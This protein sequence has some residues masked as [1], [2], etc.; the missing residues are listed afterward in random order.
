MPGR[1]PLHRFVRVLCKLAL[2]SAI[3]TLSA[4][5][6]FYR[7]NVVQIAFPLLLVCIWVYGRFLWNVENPPVTPDHWKGRRLL[8]GLLRPALAWSRR[9][10]P[11]TAQ[12]L[13]DS[14]LLLYEQCRFREAAEKLDKAADLFAQLDDRPNQS[15]ALMDL[16]NCL[17]DAGRHE[18]AIRAHTQALK[19]WEQLAEHQRTNNTWRLLTNL[20]AALSDKG[21]LEAAEAQCRRALDHCRRHHADSEPEVAICLLNLADVQRRRNRLGD[22]EEGL[23]AAL[24]T[25]RKSRDTSLGLGLFLLA[26]LRE[27]QGRTAEADGLYLEGRA[28]MEKHLG[29]DHADVARL[30]ERHAE[31]LE[32]TGRPAEAAALWERAAGIRS[33]C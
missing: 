15:W 1:R 18:E 6:L 32:R 26:M 13:Y 19:V 11:E 2:L 9:H 21:D 24:A 30:L 3:A 4:A 27:D 28:W 12:L 33:L 23:C 17:N 31:L 10:S 29:A 8:Q 22:A 5:L 14:G 16:G 20:G 7:E 25:L